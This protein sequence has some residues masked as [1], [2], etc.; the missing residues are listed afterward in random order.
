M[1]SKLPTTWRALMADF[2][3][4]PVQATDS[5]ALEQA[6]LCQLHRPSDTA[7]QNESIQAMTCRNEEVTEAKADGC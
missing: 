5:T 4:V 7:G 2:L 3:A 1:P 6:R